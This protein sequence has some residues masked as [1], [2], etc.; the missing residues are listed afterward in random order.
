MKAGGMR[1]SDPG[2]GKATGM[3]HRLGTGSGGQRGS[4]ARR[5]AGLN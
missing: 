3:R 2:G 1:S 5:K 4:R